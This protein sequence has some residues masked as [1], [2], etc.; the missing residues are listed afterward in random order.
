MRRTVLALA[1]GALGGLAAP[2]C[3]AESAHGPGAR[4]SATASD[5]PV[6]REERTIGTSF[7]REV[8]RTPEQRAQ[9]EAAR[10]SWMNRAP[11]NPL[12]GDH[13]YPGVDA[14]HPSPTPPPGR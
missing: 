7:S 3:V 5:A 14:R 10:Q 13:T 8:C 12:I 4:Y 6:C 11:A 2:A 9:D 1:L